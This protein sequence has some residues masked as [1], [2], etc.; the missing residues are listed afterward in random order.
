MSKLFIM[1]GLPGSGKSYFASN[2][3]KEIKAIWLNSDAIRSAMYKKPDEVVDPVYRYDAVFGAMDYFAS[4]LLKQGLDVI[5]DANNSTRNMRDALRALAKENA[6]TTIVVQLKVSAD[7]AKERSKS[8]EVNEHQ[9]TMTDEKFE[10]HQNKIEIPGKDELFID[11]DGTVDFNEQY[12]SFS[13]QLA[14]L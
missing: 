2:L 8:R 3:S 14:E 13:K 1:M 12:K 11:I 5:Y 9:R 6:P 4:K 10:K 7:I